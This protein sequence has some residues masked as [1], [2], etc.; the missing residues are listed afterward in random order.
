M[1]LTPAKKV[2]SQIGFTVPHC[3]VCLL[4]VM[5]VLTFGNS[6]RALAAWN[7]HRHDDDPGVNAVADERDASP[8]SS[9]SAHPGTNPIP[10][11]STSR[12]VAADRTEVLRVRLLSA[13]LAGIGVLGLLGIFYCYLKLDHATRGMYSRRLQTLC[14]FLGMLIV[15]GISMAYLLIQQ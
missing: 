3:L 11:S 2:R 13:L 12:I 1:M 4:G 8:T 10:D 9:P 5:M 6:T 7:Q 14:I 15:V